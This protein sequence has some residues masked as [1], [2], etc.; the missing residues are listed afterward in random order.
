MMKTNIAERQF[1][2]GFGYSFAIS[3]TWFNLL[4]INKQKKS[5]LPNAKCDLWMS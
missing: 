3:K 1:A 5:K 2:I 4:K